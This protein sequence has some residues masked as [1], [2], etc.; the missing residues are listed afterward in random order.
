MLFSQPACRAVVMD[1]QPG[2]SMGEH[3]VHESTVIQVV[4][5]AV[6]I[7]TDGRDVVCEAGAMVLFAPGERHAVRADTV[8]RLLLVLAPWPGEGHYQPGQDA[9]PAHVPQHAHVPPL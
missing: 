2:E 7:N 4:S 5:G 3:S 8:T 1:L 9:D 6:T